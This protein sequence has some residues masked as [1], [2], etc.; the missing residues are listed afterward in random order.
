MEALS[1]FVTAASDSLQFTISLNV[2][3]SLPDNDNMPEEEAVGLS[4]VL[5]RNCVDGK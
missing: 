2:R 3:Q 5:H 4:C 1:F